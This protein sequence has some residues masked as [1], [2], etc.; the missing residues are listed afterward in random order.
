ML[1][2]TQRTESEGRTSFGARA[3]GQHYMVE[4]LR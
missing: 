4:I 1:G 2:L 3:L